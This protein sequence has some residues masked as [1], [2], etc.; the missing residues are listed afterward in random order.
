MT[1]IK[2][3]KDQIW[4]IKRDIQIEEKKR[5]EWAT[6]VIHLEQWNKYILLMSG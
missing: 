1:E 4:Y 6:T 2:A 5:E 3:I